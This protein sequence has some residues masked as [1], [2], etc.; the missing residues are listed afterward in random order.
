MSHDLRTPL[1]TLLLYTEI[2]QEGRYE[3]PAPADS[4][5]VGLSSIHTM[6]ENMQGSCLVEQEE[7]RFC[8]R[9]RFPLQ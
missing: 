2:L 8:I 1:T 7:E 6:M 3:T 9:L 4:T 5:R